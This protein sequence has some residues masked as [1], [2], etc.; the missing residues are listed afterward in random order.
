MSVDLLR[1]A[2]TSAADVKGA[3]AIVGDWPVDRRRTE[4]YPGLIELLRDQ[5]CDPPEPPPAPEALATVLRFVFRE[6]VHEPDLAARLY[7]AIG[8]AP[9][10]CGRRALLELLV[11]ARDRRG[12]ALLR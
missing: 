3:L 7:A 4:V 9:V 10:R 2:L 11:A 5:L 8:D 1:R 12:V 6:L